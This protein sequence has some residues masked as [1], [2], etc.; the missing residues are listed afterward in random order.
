MS[1]SRTR[2]DENG[3]EEITISWT[4]D[5][6]GDA[7]EVLYGLKGFIINVATVPSATAAP[8]ADS[9]ITLKRNTG[10]TSLDVFDGALA[11]RSAT[12][13]EQVP[14]ANTGIAVLTHVNGDYTFA[15]ANAGASKEG[16]CIIRIRG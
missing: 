13:H 15:V 7:S 16:T 11:D 8:T 6:S 3:L 9:D 12:N 5:G 4:S 2:I 14:A 10:A 1:Y